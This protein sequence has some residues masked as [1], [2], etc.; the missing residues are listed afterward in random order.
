MLEYGQIVY[1]HYA[2]L[3]SRLVKAGQLV[4]KGQI[5][6]R[7]G[8][9]GNADFVHCHF[10]CKLDLYGGVNFYPQWYHSKSF[11][12]THYRDPGIYIA[13]PGIH[14][15]MIFDHL[16][17]GFLSWT[18]KQYHPGWDLNR[19]AGDSDLNDPVYATEDAQVLYSDYNSGWGN[20]IILQ[21]LPNTTV[22]DEDIKT[23]FRT[24]WGKE[25]A[26][27]DWYYFRRRIEL[28]TIANTREDVEE[29]ISYQFGKFQ[30]LGDV[31]WQNEKAKV[32]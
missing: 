10:D 30:Q 3:N 9:T 31:Y 1:P 21:T 27:G 7:V 22:T 17:Y 13:Q 16:G 2:H 6:G 19:G 8:K 32:L 14:R 15:P 12:L 20:H 28:G 11:I 23:F 29:K 26:Y 18:G 25:P 24:I 4:E 5:I